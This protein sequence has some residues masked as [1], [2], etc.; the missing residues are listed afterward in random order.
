MTQASAVITCPYCNREIPLDE[1]LTHQIREKARK[2]FN[3]EMQKKDLELKEKEKSL[4]QK[5][6]RMDQLKKDLEKRSE[7][8]K[9]SLEKDFQ[10]KLAAQKKSAEE[11]ARKK[12][13]ED[14]AL[15]LKDLRGQVEEKS[16][17]LNES[18]AQEL[19][20]RRERQKLEEEKQNLE[21]DVARKLD[22]ERQKIREE[23]TQRVGEQHKLKDAERDKLIDDMK[24]QIEELKTKAE[25]GSQQLQGE[26]LELELE[27]LL[28]QHFVHDSIAPVPKG[29]RGAD[30]IQRVCSPNGERCGTII[31]ESKRTKAWSDSWIDKL[32]EDQREAKA[33]VAVIISTVLPKGASGLIQQVNGI[34]VADYTLAVGIAMALR[35]GLIQ[36]ASAK[37][38][39][40][41]KGEKMEMLY[42]YLA[43]PEFRQQIEGIVE[44]FATMKLDLDAERRSME[45]IWAKREKQIERVVRNTGR[46]YGSLQGIIGSTLPELKALEMKAIG[47]C[48]E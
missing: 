8:M 47:E 36:V 35:S 11:A 24:K 37:S 15:E 31:W 17:Q 40:V 21:L 23:V 14:L 39:L 1:V 38:S 20:L 44:A 27:E 2:E 25:L 18:K 3:E 7:E 9:E 19:A 43:G 34:W 16:K 5:E 32:K 4:L 48:D 6:S 42:E 46:M 33:D 30:V 28:R 41:G 29:M 13:Q 45:K 22:A 10:Q 12:A 26:V